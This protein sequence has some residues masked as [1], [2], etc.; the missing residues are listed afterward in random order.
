MLTG[1]DGKIMVDSGFGTSEKQFRAELA[2]ISSDTLK[3]LINTHWHFDHT[4]G[5]EWLHKTAPR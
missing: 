1:P 2:T 4:D 3:L 5:N